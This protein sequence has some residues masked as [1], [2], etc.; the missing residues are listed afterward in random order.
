LIRNTDSEQVIACVCMSVYMKLAIQS[1]IVLSFRKRYLIQPRFL[2]PVMALCLGT[3]VTSPYITLPSLSCYT[4]TRA[5][6]H[7]RT[8][9]HT[10]THKVAPALFLIEHHAMKAYWG[11]GGIASRSGR[12]TPRQRA[13]G[14][15]W[16]G[17]W[18]GPRAVLDAVVKRKNGNGPSGSIRKQYI[19]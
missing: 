17:G 4:Y 18:V 13:P 14:T 5:R 12:F 3:A 8:H 10:H 7:A 11:C 2:K 19:F 6:A 1:Y 15:H 16:I 9:T